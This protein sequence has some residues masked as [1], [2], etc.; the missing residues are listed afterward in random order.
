MTTSRPRS[1]KTSPF[2]CTYARGDR[3]GGRSEE[4]RRDNGCFG[5]N[6]VDMVRIESV[7]CSRSMGEIVK[8]LFGKYEANRSIDEF[9]F[10]WQR[11]QDPCA[12]LRQRTNPSRHLIVNLKVQVTISAEN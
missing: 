7:G 5:E 12:D 1:A 6:H 8:D 11:P 10:L 9:S 4:Q 2:D 3:S